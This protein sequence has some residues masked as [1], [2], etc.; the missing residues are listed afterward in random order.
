[1]IL[2]AKIK[3]EVIVLSE[4]LDRRGG[5]REGAGRKRIGSNRALRITL[6]NEDWEHVDRLIAE[7]RFKSYADY[8]R[9]LY[10]FSLDNFH[11]WS[12][13]SAF[14][15]AIL[16]AQKKGFTDEQIKDLVRSLHRVFDTVSLEEAAEFY[17]NS[18]Y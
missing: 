11:Q 4:D 18:D 2:E 16:A 14:G 13:Q 9:S 7:G 8:F 5:A 10:D 17:R 6:P 12:N 3:K 15:Y 1:M